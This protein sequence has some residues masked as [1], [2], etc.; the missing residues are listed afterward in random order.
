MNAMNIR[1]TTVAITALGLT[2][3]LV[4]CSN[5]IGKETVSVFV[6]TYSGEVNLDGSVIEGTL[7]EVNGCLAIDAGDITTLIVAQEQQ[8]P[9][10]DK[11]IR[12]G[13]WNF[14][15]HVSLPGSR[16]TDI[17][18]LPPKECGEVESYWLLGDISDTE[19]L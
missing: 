18:S 9:L 11:N 4:A 12:D 17:S 8:K 5:D 6:P 16:S 7:L 13:K 15:E 1:R 10:I 3:V 19:N 14:T 2:T